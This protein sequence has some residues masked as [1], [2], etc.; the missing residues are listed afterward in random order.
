MTY[1]RSHSQCDTE[2]SEGHRVARGVGGTMGKTCP[3]Q[4]T[5][6]GSSASL[7]I[8][9]LCDLDLEQT[10]SQYFLLCMATWRIRRSNKHVYEVADTG[11]VLHK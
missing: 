7:A 4:P 6:L 5:D 9:Q 1:P 10:E 2:H 3:V 8:D 11:W